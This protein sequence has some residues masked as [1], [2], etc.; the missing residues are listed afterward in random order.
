MLKEKFATAKNEKDIVKELLAKYNFQ[1][2]IREIKNEPL[3][4]L[5]NLDE[6]YKPESEKLG[7]KIIFVGKFRIC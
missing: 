7:N 6:T 4:P 1:A 2:A 5:F 3:T